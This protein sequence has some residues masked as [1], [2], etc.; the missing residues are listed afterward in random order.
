MGDC[1]R[2]NTAPIDGEGE[3]VRGNDEWPEWHGGKTLN[4]LN[5]ETLKR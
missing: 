2:A 1:R 4:P 5:R 3:A